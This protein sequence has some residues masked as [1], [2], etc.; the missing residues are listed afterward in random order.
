MIASV[1]FP[2]PATNLEV[3]VGFGL[4]VTKTTSRST[5]DMGDQTGRSLIARG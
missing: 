1:Q 5:E 4:F 2:V 3:V